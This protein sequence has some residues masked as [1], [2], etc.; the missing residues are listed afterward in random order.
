MFC[1]KCRQYTWDEELCLCK[2][3]N[4][5]DEDGGEYEIWGRDEDEAALNFARQLYTTKNPKI[6]DDIQLWDDTTF[7]NKAKLKTYF[8]HLERLISLVIWIKYGVCL[9]RWKLDV[10]RRTF[11][12]VFRKTLD[13]GENARATYC[14]FWEVNKNKAIVFSNINKKS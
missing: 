4:V 12:R 6:A 8:N 7:L 1:K 13:I 9:N 14:N 2:K 10:F 3:F 5:I 11:R